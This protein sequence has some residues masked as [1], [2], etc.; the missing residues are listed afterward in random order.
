MDTGQFVEFVAQRGLAVVATIGGKGE[1]QA[2]L[3]GVAATSQG[4]IVFDTLTSSRKYRNISS[5]PRVALVV[6]WDDE[7]TLQCE[8]LADLPLGEDLARCQ[9]TSFAQ[10]PDGRQRAASPDIRHVRV[11][12]GWL[13][14]SDYRP[15]SFT[16]EDFELT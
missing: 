6:G 11:R 4:E 8:G 7:V 5:N 10:Y 13:R 1:P 15:D 12:P 2:A 9:S 16:I 14:Y 3:V